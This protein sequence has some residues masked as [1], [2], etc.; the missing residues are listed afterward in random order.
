MGI[1]FHNVVEFSDFEQGVC[2][3]VQRVGGWGQMVIG[4]DEY[5]CADNADT[6]SFSANTA[7][8]FAL[9]SN[10]IVVDGTNAITLNRP[11]DILRDYA[12]VSV[13]RHFPKRV[14]SIVKSYALQT[15][16]EAEHL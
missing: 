8:W 2:S 12:A 7:L 15:P 1:Y 11:Y 9:F 13:R 16:F 10:G 3:D 4:T 6:C 5:S 14:E